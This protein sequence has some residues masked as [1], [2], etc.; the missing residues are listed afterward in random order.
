MLLRV[1]LLYYLKQEVIGEEAEKIFCNA[2]A[3]EID[4]PAPIA[5]GEL[6]AYWW[7]EDADRSLLIGV[8][9]HGQWLGTFLLFG[10]TSNGYQ[11]FL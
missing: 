2:P 5:D 1:R 6:P 3:S 7:D 11:F 4:I 8:F 9:K 10:Y